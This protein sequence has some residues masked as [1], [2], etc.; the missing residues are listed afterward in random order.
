MP[1]SV[2]VWR[3][4]KPCGAA[5]VTTAMRSFQTAPITVAAATANAR[6]FSGSAPLPDVPALWQLSS[7]VDAAV[8]QN[9]Q[10]MWLA[11]GS[12]RLLPVQLALACV[13]V[14]SSRPNFGGAIAGPA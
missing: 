14:S 3:S 6:G 9:T 2:T 5:V 7:A 4:A 13:R 10:A 8:P 12:L 11:L 1:A